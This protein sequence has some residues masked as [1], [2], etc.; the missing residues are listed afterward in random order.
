MVG[1]PTP[2]H[3]PLQELIQ[4]V[5]VGPVLQERLNV[6]DIWNVPIPGRVLKRAAFR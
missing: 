5:L 2:A 3:N 6:H 4:V 1:V